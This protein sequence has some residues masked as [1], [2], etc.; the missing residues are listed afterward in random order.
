MTEVKGLQPDRTIQQRAP[1]MRIACLHTVESNIEIF[2]LAARALGPDRCTLNY[3]VRSY[4]LQSA[5]RNGGLTRGIKDSATSCRSPRRGERRRAADVL[6]PGA[7]GRR[8]PGR[9]IDSDQAGGWC[10]RAFS[11]LASIS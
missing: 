6:D 2:E 1:S 11:L 3:T 5:E 4:L 10:A 8:R 7:D 9:N